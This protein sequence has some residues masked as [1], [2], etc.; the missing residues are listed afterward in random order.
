M[1]YDVIVIGGGHAGCEAA[2][3][4]AR[5]GASTL[6]VTM[7]LAE[8]AKT[9]CNPSVGG[10]AKSHLVFE[11]DALGGEI[12]RNADFTGIH[13]KVLNTSKGPAV[14]AN[15]VQVDKPAYAVRMQN[16]LKLQANLSVMEAEVVEFVISKDTIRGIKT[17]TGLTVEAKA[18]VLTPGTFLGGTVHIGMQK[19]ASG[20]WK[21]DPS[22][23]LSDVIK[24]YGLR[25]ARLKTGTPPRLLDSTVDYGKMECH[26]FDEPTPF[27]SW[28]GRN[29]RHMFHVE[30]NRPEMFHVEQGS[31][32]L[33]WKPGSDQVNCFITHTTEETH[34]I[35]RS[36]LNESAMYGGQIEGT[37][38][39]YCPSV[40]DKVV[41]FADKKSHHVFIEPEGRNNPLIYPNGISNSLPES[42]QRELVH[43]IPGLENSTIVT[44]A[45]AIEYDFIDPTQLSHSLQVK[46]LSGLFLA[47]QVNGTTGY[48]E[49]AAQGFMAGVNAARVACGGNPFT[50]RRD[51]AYIGILI[52]DLVT[53]G[54][55]EPYRMFTSLSE[56]RLTL[57]QDN[58][59]YRL[60]THSR[61]LGICD[62][63][64]MEDTVSV[65]NSISAEIERMGR[66]RVEGKSLLEILR[67]PDMSYMN[68][69]GHNPNLQEEVIEQIEI[70]LKYEG[71]ITREQK[72]ANRMKRDEAD[73]IPGNLDFTKVPSLRREAQEKFTKVQPA[74]LGHALRIPGIS[75]ADITVLAFY[76]RRLHETSKATVAASADQTELPD[77]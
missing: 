27:L 25:T 21:E 42:V 64:F 46:C 65:Q 70:Q 48:E 38:V 43:S 39:R 32:F 29:G 23:A 73:P 56:F 72:L 4:S 11:I 5:M 77:R 60:L 66:T 75:P 19:F 30:Q 20:R 50:L 61:E 51:E 6:L 40:E 71:Y 74:S 59:R 62:P 37:G 7:K 18:V 9:P 28:H 22:N 44:P 47:G 8:I 55:E 34:R 14:R 69:E 26:P 16:V 36:H 10:I 68:M 1:Y 12:A 52:D 53:R 58:A 17:S 24:K 49:A 45:Y 3:A 31:P 63:A 67:R 54:T 2:L 76:L 57:R 41:K 13:F 15:R 33:P 35:I